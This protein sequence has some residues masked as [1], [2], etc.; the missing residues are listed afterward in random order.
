MDNLGEVVINFIVSMAVATMLSSLI[1]ICPVNTIK[2][3]KPVVE[4]VK[5]VE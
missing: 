2:T 5:E 3:T 1:I 4:V